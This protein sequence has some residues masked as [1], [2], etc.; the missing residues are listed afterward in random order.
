MTCP[1]LINPK[2]IKII[3]I[4]SSYIHELFTHSFVFYMYSFCPLS[5]L[6]P[7]IFCLVFMLILFLAQSIHFHFALSIHFVL[8]T[9]V[10]WVCLLVFPWLV[11]ICTPLLHKCFVF[12]L[13]LFLC[14]CSTRT[15][16]SCDPFLYKHYVFLRCFNL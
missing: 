2:L 3:K 12:L 1:I 16:H 8:C 5:F 4:S 15:L 14:S 10:L 11:I 7:I 13:L 9:F 6:I